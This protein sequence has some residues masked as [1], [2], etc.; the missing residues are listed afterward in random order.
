MEKNTL[1]IMKSFMLS[2]SKHERPGDPPFDKLRANGVLFFVQGIMPI[3][4]W[5]DSTR[6]DSDC[7]LLQRFPGEHGVI[8]PDR[9]D[10]IDDKIERNLFRLF[11][12][13]QQEGGLDLLPILFA[14]RR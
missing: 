11:T 13:F 2:L 6:H 3:Q 1:S 8:H 12:G 9:A 4:S 10:P 5:T 14:S 7:L